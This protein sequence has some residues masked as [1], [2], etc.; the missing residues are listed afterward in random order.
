MFSVACFSLALVLMRF[1]DLIFQ[2]HILY[3][4]VP[5]DTPVRVCDCV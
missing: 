3:H 1:D 5:H 2:D 4:S